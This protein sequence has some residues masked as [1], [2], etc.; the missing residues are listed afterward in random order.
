[1]QAGGAGV[2][3]RDTS[4]GLGTRWNVGHQPALADKL[5]AGP[6]FT[7]QPAMRPAEEVQAEGGGGRWTPW[8]TWAVC[9]GESAGQLLV[10]R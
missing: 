8:D 3:G 7:F 9:T 2:H 5:R 1:M 4:R 6:K 10:P